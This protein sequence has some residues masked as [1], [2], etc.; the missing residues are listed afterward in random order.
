MPT[1]QE[2]K[3]IL[4]TIDVVIAGGKTAY[5]YC[6][7]GIGRTERMVGCFLAR[8]GNYNEQ[9]ALDVSFQEE[10]TRERTHQKQEIKWVL[11]WNGR[12]IYTVVDSSTWKYH[13]SLSRVLLW[14]DV[15]KLIKKETT[16]TKGQIHKQKK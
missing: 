16:E 3:L 11:S 13:S 6:G 1:K 12:R 8:N 9:E 10:A 7:E 5:V 15:P 2:M 4:D 14:Q